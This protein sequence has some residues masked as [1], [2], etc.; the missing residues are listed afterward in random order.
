MYHTEIMDTEQIGT[1]LPDH[2]LRN[3]TYALSND[4]TALVANVGLLRYRTLTANGQNLSSSPIY[5]VWIAK[6]L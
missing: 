4:R 5:H 2:D 6:A 1:L 3:K